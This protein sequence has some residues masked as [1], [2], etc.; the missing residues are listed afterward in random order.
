MGNAVA[1]L[2]CVVCQ[3]PYV[4][5]HCYLSHDASKHMLR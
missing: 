4:I 5:T 1:E 3:L 2:R